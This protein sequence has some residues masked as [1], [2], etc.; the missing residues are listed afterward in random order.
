MPDPRTITLFLCGDV[1]TGRGIDQI[2]PHP[3]EPTIH[4]PYASSAL[5]YLALAERAAGPVPRPVDFAY[6]W[7]D[8]LT[9]LE[10]RAPDLRIANLETSITTSREAQPRGINY[11]MHP[12]NAPCLR[13]AGLDCCVLANNHVIDW[14][15]SGLLETLETLRTAGIVTAGAGG[16]AE[17]AARPA[18]LTAPDGGRVLVFGFGSPSSGVPL[19]WAATEDRAGVNVLPDLSQRTAEGIAAQ[20]ATHRREGDLVV[21]SIHWGGNWGYEIPREQREF[22]HRLIDAGSVDVVHGHSSHHPKGIE[23]YRGRSILY[24]CGDFINDYEGIHGYEE[25][26]KLAPAY[27]LTLD[28]DSGRLADLA[29]VP[30][31]SVRFRLQRADRSEA[32]W[33]RQLLDREGKPLGTTATL[34][35][36]GVSVLR[37]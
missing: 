33:L 37:W 12:R 24:G 31:R 32:E 7:G 14:G 10:A 27:F 21:A 17:E 3:S 11:R 1:M 23:H 26:R 16:D 29:V 34:A 36:D 28:A 15:I 6:I 8:A 13:V 20:I 9:E 4:E 2:L 18:V 25:F 22:A 5:E 30:F 19:L 35:E